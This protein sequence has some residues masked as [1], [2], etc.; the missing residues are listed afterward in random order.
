[1][2]KKLLEF[3]TIAVGGGEPVFNARRNSLGYQQIVNPV[4]AT[5]I[6][7]PTTTVQTLP[8]GYVVKPGTPGLAIIQCSGFPVRWRD[9]GVAPTAGLGMNLAV[10][11]ELDYVGD[12]GSI[13]FINNGGAATLDITLFV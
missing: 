10:G 7:M 9:D 4:A 2:L 11:Q 3:L 5:G 12:I 1:M 13:Q 8:G 6:V